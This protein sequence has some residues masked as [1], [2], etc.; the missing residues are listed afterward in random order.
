MQFWLG[1]WPI[2]GNGEFKSRESHDSITIRARGSGSKDFP[3]I[4]LPDAVFIGARR[5]Q[6]PIC[7]FLA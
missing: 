6:R 2:S 3:R 4:E 5:E 1:K 7:Y